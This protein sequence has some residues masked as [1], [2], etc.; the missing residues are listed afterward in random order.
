MRDK[1]NDYELLEIEINKLKNTF[2][3]SAAEKSDGSSF[4]WSELTSGPGRKAITIGIVLMIVNQ[5]SGCFPMLSYIAS[6]FKDAGSN[7][8][9]NMSAMIV[10]AVQ[11]LGS[12]VTTN[13][14]DRTGRKV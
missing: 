9:P 6:I 3:S 14:V 13:L 8:S 10:G 2:N 12:Y 7:L 1:N 11:L 4:K 5:F